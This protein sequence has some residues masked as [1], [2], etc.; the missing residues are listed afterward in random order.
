MIGQ[1]QEWTW[2]EA[3]QQLARLSVANRAHSMHIG[4]LACSLQQIERHLPGWQIG[5]CEERQQCVLSPRVFQAEV[6][7]VGTRM[8]LASKKTFALKQ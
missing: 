6:A 2:E 3:A 7:Q 4:A 5:W 8:R 1:K